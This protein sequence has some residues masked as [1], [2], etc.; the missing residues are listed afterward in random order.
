RNTSIKLD[1]NAFTGAADVDLSGDKPVMSV[2]LNA[3]A[4]NLKGLS[5]N[6]D[7]QGAG[8]SDGGGS[9]GGSSNGWPKDPINASG[10]AAVNGEFALVADS[11]DL[12]DF[13]L[14][15]TRTLAKLEDSS[16]IRSA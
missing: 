6:S 13:K 5:A 3:G 9:G 1:G 7:E 12:G 16:G 8:G 11:I 4:L 2:Q 14:A 15:K 10:L